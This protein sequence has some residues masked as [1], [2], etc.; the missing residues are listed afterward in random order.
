MKNIDIP[1]RNYDLLLNDLTWPH[2]TGYG[3]PFT[4]H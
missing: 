2:S 1:S 3:R 4:P